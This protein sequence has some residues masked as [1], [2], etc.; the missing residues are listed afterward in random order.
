MSD[1]HMENR[2]TRSFHPV[3]FTVW[4][5]MIAST[6]LFAAFSSA[7]IV[8]RS[9]NLRN[10]EWLQF[11]IPDWFF[12]STGIV[13]GTSILIQLA[14]WLNKKGS[15]AVSSLLIF[16][17]ILGGLLFGWSQ[18]QGYNDLVDM[19]IYFRSDSAAGISGSFFYVITGI[20]LA[21]IL[22]GLL[23]LFYTLIQSLRGKINSEKTLMMYV[24]SVYW[25]FL[26]FLWIYLFLFLYL[27]R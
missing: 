16:L 7:Y 23:I 12:I 4:L 2:N 26:G 27:T 5:L 25:H 14:T 8:H 21:H 24:S 17:T 11:D 15:R 13:I 18:F 1:N 9:D 19:G 22:L 3:K 10:G 6:M 20:H